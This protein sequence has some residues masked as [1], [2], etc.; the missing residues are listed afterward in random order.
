[1]VMRKKTTANCDKTKQLLVQPRQFASL[2]TLQ[3]W[4]PTIFFL[5]QK[6]KSVRKVCRF[7]TT[8]E[9]INKNRKLNKYGNFQTL[10]KI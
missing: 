6:L 8:V 2:P 7:D 10:Y 5:F 3:I 9:L 1:M 4:L